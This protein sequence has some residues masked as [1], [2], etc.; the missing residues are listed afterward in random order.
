MS[1]TEKGRKFPP[2]SERAAIGSGDLAHE[3]AAALRREFGERSGMTKTVARI[4]GA[5][6]R[7]VKNWLAGSHGPSGDHLIALM[8][9]SEEVLA[10]VLRL[11]GR[12][13]LLQGNRI[14]DAETRLQDSLRVM[15]ELLEEF[16]GGRH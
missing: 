16:R 5:R 4:A 13:A 1:L 2:D 10:A 9:Q 12:E 7:T 15:G 3:V 8:R 6:E 11:S 14:A